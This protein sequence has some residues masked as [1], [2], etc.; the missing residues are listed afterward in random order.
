MILV[1]YLYLSIR[2]FSP[3]NQ[4]SSLPPDLTALV[5]TLFE[6]GRVDFMMAEKKT[7]KS[8]LHRN[9]KLQ[10]KGFLHSVVRPKTIGCF[11]E[12]IGCFSATVKTVRKD[13]FKLEGG[14][15]FKGVFAIFSKLE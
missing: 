5:L 12:T 9:L 7:E 6:V 10:L 2:S 3:E 14:E 13:G 4:P 1:S 8:S 15:L 11:E